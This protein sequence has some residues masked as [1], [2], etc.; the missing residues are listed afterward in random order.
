MYRQQWAEIQ[1]GPKTMQ[2]DFQYPIDP[3][4]SIG[5]NVYNDKSILLVSSGALATFGY[6]VRV[7]SR[8][9]LGFGLSGGFV[10]NQIDLDDVPDIDLV[11]PVLL[12]ASNS[13][14]FDGQFGMH[15]RNRNFILGLSLLKLVDNRPF[16]EGSVVRDTFDPF[17]DRAAII[18]YRIGVS[19]NI[20]LQPTV[21]YRSTYYGYE[22]FEGSL[23]IGYKNLI[24]I[25][26]GYRLDY[27]PHAMI[28]L[29]LNDLHAGYSYDFPNT[30]YGGSPGGTHEVQLKYQLKRTTE[31]LASLVKKDTV[32]KEPEAVAEEPPRLEEKPVTTESKPEEKPIV[33]EVKEPVIVAQEPVVEKVDVSTEQQTEPVIEEEVDGPMYDLVVGVFARKFHAERFARQLQNVGIQAIVKTKS[34]TKLF[35]VTAP[36]YATKT[37]SLPRIYEIRHETKIKDAWFEI[38]K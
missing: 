17:K 10:S 19:E 33:E 15:Y 18:G 36:K 34:D 12:N 25:G 5:L 28:R 9:I 20:Y 13:F 32:Q 6:R 4:I 30:R 37:I 16:S 35:Y 31:D 29:R 26:G 11:D 7:T 22:Y 8:H 23:Q 1:N 27:G 21:Y 2:L 24:T 3:R 38:L 14:G